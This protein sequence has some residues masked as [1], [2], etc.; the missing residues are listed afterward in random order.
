MELTGS[1]ALLI[2]ALL[3]SLNGVHCIPGNLQPDTVLQ[4]RWLSRAAS[5]FWDYYL[6]T[7]VNRSSICGLA[8][9]EMA[10][11]LEEFDSIWA[12]KMV[13]SWGKSDDGILYGR[14][15]YEGSYDECMSVASPEKNFRGKYCRMT[16]RKSKSDSEPKSQKLLPPWFMNRPEVRI[17][18]DI[19]EST[20]EGTDFG[21]S[22]CIPSV[23][24]VEDL[25]ESVN[26]T[27]SEL[28]ATLQSLYC[29]EEYSS[30]ELNAGDYAYIIVM[31][32]LF[33]VVLIAGLVDILIQRSSNQKPAKGGIR[34]LLVFS[35]YTNMKKMFH[36]NT[37]RTP[38]VITCLNGMRVLSMVW[39]VY[40]HQQTKTFFYNANFAEIPDAVS[41]LPYQIISN[42]YP[43]V[44]TFFFLS[45]LLVTYNLLKEVKRN[46]MFN[47]ILF[48]VHRLIRLIPPILVVSGLYGTVVRFFVT[49]PFFKYWEYFMFSECKKYFWKNILMVSNFNL[50]DRAGSCLGQCW[51]VSVDSQLYLVAPFFILPL[52]YTKRFGKIWLYL[53]TLMSVIIPASIIYV[54]DLPPSNVMVGEKGGEYFEK[55]YLKPWTRA[56]PWVVGIWLGYI[57]YKQ[58][59][60]KVILK[61]WQVVAGWSVSTIA[62]LLVQFGMY[63]YNTVPAK[64]MYEIMTQITY[65]GFQRSVWAAC[66]AWIVFACHNGYGGFV[67][68]ILSHP[69][70]QPLSRLTYSLYLVAF[71]M[72]DAIVFSART[73]FVFSH[74][75][76]IF[77]TTGVLFISSVVSVL[78]SLTAESPILGLEKLLLT[79]PAR[80][81]NP[82]ITKTTDSHLPEDQNGGID[83]INLNEKNM[84]REILGN[85]NPIFTAEIDNSKV[86]QF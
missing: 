11:S 17:I 31:S 2:L 52:V 73:H 43:S 5:Q 16:L 35:F 77:E 28:S 20:A 57:F 80:P 50:E 32:I 25:W 3:G 74:I 7:R 70:W 47:P 56:G 19:I 48:Y 84:Q 14:F 13:D 63:S 37:E 22:T 6:P 36:L 76:K 85:D 26:V 41:N 68:G 44:D 71:L 10:D 38:G 24:S 51:Y 59:K 75:N 64:A 39:V 12:A 79:R 81:V 8:I 40:G 65:G 4:K 54:N 82:P 72:A 86:T 66:L 62:A 69:V 46:K 33:A 30:E 23:C 27:Y 34:F 9:Q 61:Q 18:P 1:L 78:V 42:A 58:G 53:V 29:K 60:E 49:G 45:G 21:Y 83:K 15:Y 67:D 55:V